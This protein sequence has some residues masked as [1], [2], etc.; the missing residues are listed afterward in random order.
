MKGVLIIGL[1]AALF[2]GQ[3]SAVYKC[4]VDGKTTFSQTKC[5]YDAEKVVL[6]AYMPSQ[7]DIQN[8]ETRAIEINEQVNKNRVQRDSRAIQNRISR[9]RSNVSRYQRNMDAELDVLRVKKSRANNNLAGATYEQA[10][11][12]EMRAVIDKYT[13][14]INTSNDQIKQLRF[15]LNGLL[16]TDQ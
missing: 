5:A 4:I 12:M 9:L 13:T 10:I 15:Q 3:A 1:I 2:S 6:D 14:K 8:A 7:A 16:A 11:A